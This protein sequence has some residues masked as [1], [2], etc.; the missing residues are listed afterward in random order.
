MRDDRARSSPADTRPVSPLRTS[1]V[2]AG[3]SHRL[4]SSIV[5]FRQPRRRPRGHWSRL[6]S[7]RDPPDWSVGWV[8]ANALTLQ[9]MPPVTS[10]SCSRTTARR[11]TQGPAVFCERLPSSWPAGLVRPAARTPRGANRP[12]AS[13]RRLRPAGPNRAGRGPGQHLP[14]DLPLSL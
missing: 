4:D 7:E 6:Q 13:R 14:A 3:N 9:L 12:R 2:P 1:R 8:P 5:R 10:E 11:G